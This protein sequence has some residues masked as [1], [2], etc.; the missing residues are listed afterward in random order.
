[1]PGLGI[2][3]SCELDLDPFARTV[4]NIPTVKQASI[5]RLTSRQ[6]SLL[7]DPLYGL[8]LQTLLSEGGD[9][10]SLGV[11]IAARVRSQLL[12]D[13]RILAVT[14]RKSTYVVETKTLD[15]VLI[16][17]TLEGPFELVFNLNPNSI[18]IISEGV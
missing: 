5:R 12:R 13:E 16:V 14:V 7:G 1:M 9:S 8:D 18:Q 17:Q 6:G 15:M 4:K 3:W 10:A 2:D 11:T